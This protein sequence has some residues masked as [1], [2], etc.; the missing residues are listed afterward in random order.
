MP[1]TGHELPYRCRRAANSQSGKLFLLGDKE[2]TA[3]DRERA[4]TQL[5]HPRAGRRRD[6]AAGVV[7]PSGSA[8]RNAIAIVI[9]V[10]AWV[11]FAWWLHGVLFGLRPPV[12]P[13][14][15][16]SNHASG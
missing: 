5:G 14:R 10:V 13:G 1:A 8:L 12:M 6:R 3:A 16:D 4:C 9:G 15:I 7:Y 11:D 2:C